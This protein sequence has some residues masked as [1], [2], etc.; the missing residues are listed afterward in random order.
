[1]VK[2]LDL[3]SYRSKRETFF[4]KFA[5]LVNLKLRRNFEQ[6]VVNNLPS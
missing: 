5:Y 4:E 3:S 2:F 1:M 6:V